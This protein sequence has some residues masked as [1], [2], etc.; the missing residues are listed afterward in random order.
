MSNK[1]NDYFI[2]DGVDSRKFDCVVFEADTFSSPVKEYGVASIPGRSGDLLLSNRRFQNVQH[3]YD[4]VIYRNF[5]EN[6]DALREFLL[7]RDGYCRL[8]DSIHPDEF[9]HAYFSE[10][11]TPSVPAMNAPR[12]D[13]PNTYAI[14]PAAMP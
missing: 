12:R 9:Y 13:R 6:F 11:I 3:V 2:F 14:R 1:S 10:S 8:E 5:A 4:V 7:G